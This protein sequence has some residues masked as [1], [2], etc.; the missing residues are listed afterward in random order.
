MVN[1]LFA[2]CCERNPTPADQRKRLVNALKAGADIEAA[3][4]NGVT[5]QAM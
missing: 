3:D 1:D 5:D 2:I 4:K